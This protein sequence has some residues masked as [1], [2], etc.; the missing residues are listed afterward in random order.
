ME[1]MSNTHI[2]HREARIID[3]LVNKETFVQKARHNLAMHGHSACVADLAKRVRISTAAADAILDII[4]TEWK[5]EYE[6]ALRAYRAQ[7]ETCN[8]NWSYRA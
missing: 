4:E 5:A 3:T 8:Y 6:E 1:T 7:D 2:T